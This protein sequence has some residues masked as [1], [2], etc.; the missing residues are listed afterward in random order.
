MSREWL[1]PAPPQLVGES[2]D[3]AQKRWYREKLNE[4]NRH[5]RDIEDYARL[6][7][8]G[9]Q[10]ADRVRDIHEQ[11]SKDLMNGKVDVIPLAAAYEQAERQV[12]ELTRKIEAEATV[13]G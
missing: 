8:G 11:V 13:L 5:L 12:G 10:L 9:M 7:H 3:K 1:G 2:L 6:Q 4:A